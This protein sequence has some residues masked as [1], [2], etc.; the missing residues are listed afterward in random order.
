MTGLVGVD[1]GGTNIRAAEATGAASHGE[2]VSRLTP[3]GS[4]PE[5]VLDAVAASARAALAGSEPGGV[6]VGVPGPLDPGTGVVYAAPHLAGWSDVPARDMLQARLGCP[7]AVHND[8]NLAGYAEWVAGAGR[9]A[10]HLVFIT[11]STGIGGCLVLDG[12]LFSGIAGTAGE[13]GHAPAT[14]DGSA[15]GQG[16]PG[17]LEGIASGTAIARRARAELEAGKAS[18]LAEAATFPDSREV[19]AAARLGDP[20]AVR[21]YAEAGR[22]LG[23]AVGGVINLLSPE[24]VVIGGGLINAGELLLQPLRSALSE[25]AFASAAARCRVVPAG[26]GTDA[27][28]VGAVAWAVRSFG[29]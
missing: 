24:V 7:V 8:A 15:C 17:C 9:G 12:E 21:L 28:L 10:R 4:G 19:A 1:L 22:A 14:L 25:I 6:A 5:A 3:A 23:R 11:V 26:L 2:P 29:G 27:G 13:L 16:H 20:L 18:V